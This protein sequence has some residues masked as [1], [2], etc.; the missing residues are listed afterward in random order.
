MSATKEMI[1]EAVDR[2]ADDPSSCPERSTT[3]PSSDTRR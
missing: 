2:L 1:V 3:T